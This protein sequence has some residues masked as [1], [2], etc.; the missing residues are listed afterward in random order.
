MSAFTEDFKKHAKDN[1]YNILSAAELT[2]GVISTAGIMP[3]SAAFDCY[4]VAKAFVV[5]AIGLLY[6][7]GALRTE[8]KV[9]EL[10]GDECPADTVDAFFALTVDDFLKH[11]IG[12]PAGYLDIDARRHE[13]YGV[14]FLSNV[15]T[16]KPKSTVGKKYTYTDAAYY[17]LAR[18]VEKLSEEPLETFLWKRLFAP[19]GFREAAWS[20]CPLGHAMGATGLFIHAED[21]VKL[22]ALYLGKG[23][24][25]GARIISETW[26]RTVLERQYELA[27]CFDGKAYGKGGMYGQMLIAIPS[28]NRAVAWQSLDSKDQTELCRWVVDYE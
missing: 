24:W 27:E 6:D 12:L 4:S 22:G 16:Q 21:M 28:K 25:N 18:V 8:D 13:I 14:D 17:V 3:Y 15:F 26:T 5:T 11:R 20:K 1:G 2:D 23:E 19:L 10:L 7:S 9:C